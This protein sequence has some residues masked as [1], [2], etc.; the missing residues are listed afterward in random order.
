MLTR[1]EKYSENHKN[2]MKIPKSRL[3]HKQSK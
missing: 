3:K 1:H 2:S